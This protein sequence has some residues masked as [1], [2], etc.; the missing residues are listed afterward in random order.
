MFGFVDISRGIDE[1]RVVSP[2]VGDRQALNEAIAAWAPVVGG[3][4]VS[5]GDLSGIENKPA[6]LQM[7][8]DARADAKRTLL[9]LDAS[10]D[11]NEPETIPLMLSVNGSRPK[12]VQLARNGQGQPN[13]FAFNVVETLVSMCPAV[14]I[15]PSMECGRLRWGKGEGESLPPENML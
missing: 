3:G 5:E 10:F 13:D 9:V 14:V 4:K 15:D 6:M 1:P 7:L 12:R 11:G 2:L 8:K